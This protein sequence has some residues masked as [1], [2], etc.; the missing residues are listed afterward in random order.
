[1][2]CSIYKGPKKIDH[3]LYVEQEDDFSRVP[4]ALLEMLG[5]LELV[6]TLELSQERT[7]AQADIHQVKAALKDQ[8]YY[9]QIPPKNHEIPAN[10]S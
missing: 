1:M 3:Y 9:F 6:M 10:I 5:A 4:K 2:H 7:L 8:G